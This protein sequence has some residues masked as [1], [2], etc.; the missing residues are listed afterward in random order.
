MVSI[1]D[2]PSLIENVLPS[3]LLN[4]KSQLFQLN[5]FT[6]EKTSL[7]F[8]EKDIKSECDGLKCDFGSKVAGI[9]VRTVFH[10]WNAMERFFLF[11]K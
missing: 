4:Q 10:K 8:V 6:S 11:M 2:L 1:S 3:V 9:P 7:H 5:V